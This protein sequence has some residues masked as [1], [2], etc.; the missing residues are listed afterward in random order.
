MKFTPFDQ[1]DFDLMKQV[2]HKHALPTLLERKINAL[3]TGLCA[4]PEFELE[5][6]S[7]RIRRR[8]KMRGHKGGL[9]LGPPRADDK[10]WYLFN[11]SGDQDQ[12]QLNIGMWQEYIR[13]GLGF[14]IG[15]QVRPK[16]PAFQVFQTFLGVRPPLPFRDAFFDSVK[17]N[18]WRI[19][20]EPDLTDPHTIIQHLET[21]VVPANADSVFVFIGALWTSQE[22]ASKDISDYRKVFLELMPFYE[23]L[24]LAGGRYVFLE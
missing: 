22:S 14:Q 11:A 9:I 3:R 4:F 19:E 8:P 21:F 24:I 17:R 2:A 20:D 23:E 12:V 6:F 1:Q 10:H 15:R 5:F 13:V 7:K 18:N 16:P